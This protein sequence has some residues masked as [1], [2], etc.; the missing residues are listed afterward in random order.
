MIATKRE[1]GV[2]LSVYGFGSPDGYN[3]PIAENLADKGNGIYFFIDSPE[4]ARRAFIHSFTGSLLTVAKD[5]KLQLQFNPSQVKGYRLIGYENRVLSNSDFNDDSVDAGELG[6]GLSVTA[7]VEII[8]ANSNA[9]VP[10]AAAGTDPL[11]DLER[12]TD[13][14]PGQEQ[15]DP[16]ALQPVTGAALLDVRIRYKGRDAA[17]SEL[18]T[19]RFAA[20]DISRPTPS[21]KHLFASGVAEFAMQL[22]GSQYLSQHRNAELADQ[23]RRALPADA[24]GAVNEVIELSRSAHSL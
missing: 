3:D 16:E 6:A 1:T 19:H 2:F 13:V 21:L 17:S 9:A 4:E 23:L 18:I 24:E 12:E 15:P 11:E 8:P 14:E 7:L 20:K 22:R 5:V 10:T